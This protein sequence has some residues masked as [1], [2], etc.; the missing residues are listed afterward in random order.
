MGKI[1]LTLKTRLL[2]DPAIKND[3]VEGMPKLRMHSRL[4]EPTMENSPGLQNHIGSPQYVR[5]PNDNEMKC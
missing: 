2:H 5:K 1:E 4:E 3:R